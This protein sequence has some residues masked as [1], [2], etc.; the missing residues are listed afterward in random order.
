MNRLR[1]LTIATYLPDGGGGGSHLPPFAALLAA[2]AELR[3][4]C[5]RD[6]GKLSGACLTAI[7]RPKLLGSFS[8]GRGMPLAP[9][10]LASQ[11]ARFRNLR[12]IDIQR[13]AGLS[14]AA[15]VLDPLTRSCPLRTAQSPGCAH[16]GEAR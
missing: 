16:R 15:S 9:H 8:F 1:G 2:C 10:D 4:L 5:F 14:S 11:A 7:P 12:E 3:T 13:M 6:A